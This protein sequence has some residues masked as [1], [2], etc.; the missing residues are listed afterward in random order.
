MQMLG[1]LRDLARVASLDQNAPV[2]L[3]HKEEI[4]TVAAWQRF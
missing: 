4:R 2:V 1:E 3:T